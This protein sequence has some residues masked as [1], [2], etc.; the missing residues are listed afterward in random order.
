LSKVPQGLSRF[1]TGIGL[2]FCIQHKIRNVHRL[3]PLVIS[4]GLPANTGVFL[5][6]KVYS[7]TASLTSHQKFCGLYPQNFFTKTASTASSIGEYT[8]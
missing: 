4:A 8:I 1:Q 7:L 3:D 2:T 6:A 5:I